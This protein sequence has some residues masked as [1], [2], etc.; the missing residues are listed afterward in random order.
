MR[1]LS[2]LSLVLTLVSACGSGS[3][4][5]PMPILSANG[6][7]SIAGQ[8]LALAYG[9]AGSDNSGAIHVILSDVPTRCS[10]LIDE[11]HYENPPDAGNYMIATRPYSSGGNGWKYVGFMVISKD[12]H[13][14]DDGSETDKI[15]AP[16]ITD[17]TV[18]IRVDYRESLSFGECVASGEFKVSRCPE[19]VP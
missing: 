4:D 18:T 6:T 12:G 19:A 3:K 8:K 13:I 9:V 2:A 17:S 11:W 5:P 1:S 15:E 14:D 7:V 10:M 16:D